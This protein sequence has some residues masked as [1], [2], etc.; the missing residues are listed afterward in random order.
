MDVTTV[1]ID[2]ATSIFQVHAIDAAGHVIVRQALRRAQVV[3]FFDRLQ[4]CLIG[5]DG[6]AS[7]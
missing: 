2:I 3:P 6:L 7:V 5:M 4:R 1:G